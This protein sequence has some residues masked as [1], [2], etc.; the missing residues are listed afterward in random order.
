[1]TKLLTLA[2]LVAFVQITSWA[3]TDPGSIAVAPARFELEMQPGTEK[4]VVIAVDYRS[5][6]PATKPVRIVATLNDWTITPDGRVEYFRAGTRDRSASP[7]IIY[8]PGEATITPGSI[9]QIRVTISVP[10]NAAPGDHLAALV[11]EQRAETLKS[12]ADLRQMVVRYRMASVFYIKVGG[13]T[14]RGSFEHLYA[15]TTDEGI[16]VTPTLKNDGNSMIRPSQSIKIVDANGT[17]VADLADIEPLPIL[18]GS[19]T[20]Q[21]IRLGKN[22]STGHYTVKMRVDFNDGEKPVEGLTDLIIAPK[23]ASIGIRHPSKP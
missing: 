12:T 10:N 18:A 16:V 23:I 11:I 6:T 3:Q 5:T 14:K 15:A 20:S 21:S 4:T 7:W 22:L 19:Q 2:F 13:L 1:M 9:H 17:I 8:S